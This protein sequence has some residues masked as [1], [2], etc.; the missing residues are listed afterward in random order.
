[1]TSTVWTPE[2]DAYLEEYYPQA[3]MSTMMRELGRTRG[4]IVYR[5][6]KLGVLRSDGGYSAKALADIFGCDLHFVTDMLDEG[7]LVGKRAPYKRGNTIP[8]VFTEDQVLAFIRTYPWLLKPSKMEQAHIFRAALR[9]EWERDPWY[10]THQAARLLGVHGET[11]LRRVRVGELTA[12]RRVN[13]PRYSHCWIRKS[14]LDTFTRKDTPE[15]R[16]KNTA[17]TQR[18]Y[19]QGLGLPSRLYTVWETVCRLCAATLQIEAAPKINGPQVA[20]FF[21]ERHQCAQEVSANEA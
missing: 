8:F 20:E 17:K 16:A 12:F 19:R 6:K 14:A 21:K 15:I 7:Y 3:K 2:Q 18:K 5:R 10:T 4:A 13:S 1:M 11:L 9:E